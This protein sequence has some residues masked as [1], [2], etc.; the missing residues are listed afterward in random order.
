MNNINIIET[1]SYKPLNLNDEQLKYISNEEKIKDALTS[2]YC[3]GYNAVIND[4]VIGFALFRQFESGKFF[5][6]DFIIDKKYQ[7][8]GKGKEFLRKLLEILRTEFNASVVTTTYIQGNNV[9]KNLYEGVG[10]FQTDIVD[11]GETHEV[12]MLLEVNR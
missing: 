1:K 11:E 3:F 10:F 6:W 12:N 7:G 9:A 8:M 4:C 2:S 5:L